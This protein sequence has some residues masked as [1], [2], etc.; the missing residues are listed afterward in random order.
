M[1]TPFYPHSV[2]GDIIRRI[3]E[4]GIFGEKDYSYLACSP[5]AVALLDISRIPGDNT[6]RFFHHV[7]VD[8]KNLAVASL[9]IKSAIAENIVCQVL[10]QYRSEI[11]YCL[12]GDETF[13]T[14]IPY[15]HSGHISQLWHF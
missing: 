6:A 5:D 2:V 3:Y 15:E 11:L 14:F 7:E 4:C 12:F 10:P 1:K 8:R 13:K 9:E